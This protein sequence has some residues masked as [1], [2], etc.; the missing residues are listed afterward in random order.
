MV[1]DRERLVAQRRCGHR[2]DLH[3]PAPGAVVGP[4]DVPAFVAEHTAHLAQKRGESAL[5]RRALCVEVFP[6]DQPRELDEFALA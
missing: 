1:G 3:Q 2:P 5:P 6:A 4:L